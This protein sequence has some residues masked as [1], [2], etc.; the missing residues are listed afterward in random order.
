MAE[1]GDVG[2]AGESTIQTLIRHASRR[3][4]E[5]GLDLICTKI[6]ID[7]QTMDEGTADARLAAGLKDFT[8][9]SGVDCSFV[10]LIDAETNRIDAVYSG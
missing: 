8:N 5:P 3:P 10:A 4:G 9:A 7:F 6:A 1:E 2:G